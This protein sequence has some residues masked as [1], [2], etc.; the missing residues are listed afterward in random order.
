MQRLPAAQ[1]QIVL[2][3]SFSIR[4]TR[5]PDPL[6]PFTPTTKQPF[7]YCLAGLGFRSLAICKG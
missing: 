4:G 1:P 7:D 2:N 6:L 5:T 3:G